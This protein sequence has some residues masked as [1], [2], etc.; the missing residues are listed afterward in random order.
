MAIKSM[1]FSITVLISMFF[2]DIEHIQFVAIITITAFILFYVKVPAT[3]LLLIITFIWSLWY[4][5]YVVNEVNRP[6]YKTA[7][8]QKQPPIKAVQ[9]HIITAQVITLVNNKKRLSF[10]VSV[11]NT[12]HTAMFFLQ[13]KLALKWSNP[14]HAYPGEVGI[15]Q[16]WRFK[17]RI[18]D[19]DVNKVENRFSSIK[20][21]LLSRHVRHTGLIMKGEVIQPE[22]SLRG[23]LYQQF[24]AIL[25]SAPNPMIM[26]LTF[27]DRSYIPN[28]LWTQFK[29]LGIGH[30]VA[31]SG[32]HIGLIFGFS[33]VCSL[34]ILRWCKINSYLAISLVF[35]LVM[36]VFYAWLAG[37]SLPALRAIV[38]LCIH[39]L[40][41]IQYYKITLFQLF[42]SMLFVTL[43]FDPLTVFSVSFWLSFSAMAA[44]FI[45]IWYINNNQNSTTE[46]SLIRQVLMNS[47]HRL[48]IVVYSQVL[49]TFLILPLQMTVFSGF[50][51]L[52]I[53]INLI[54]IP[55]FSVLILPVLLFAVLLVPLMPMLSQFLIWIANHLLN[56]IQLLWVSLTANN[57]VWFDLTGHINT[58]FYN[59]FLMIFVLLIIAVFIKPLRVACNSISLLLL[60]LLCYTYMN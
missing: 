29:L 51:W 1:L 46:N 60:P 35:S 22:F 37:F 58:M 13:P 3:W 16:I 44:V 5:H 26:A 57:A 50:S 21:R 49:L 2:V 25:P 14:D 41:R 4:K 52:S 27:G 42:S 45:L 19:D 39:C 40:Y 7:F 59:C 10:D 54:F 6:F 23:G 15:G 8:Q 31:I 48:K 34:R 38:L 12:S 53:I 56:Y 47:F 24:K 36:A 11:I 43:L 9:D 32:L 30:L 28:D 18:M 33:Y 20:S 17:I 55:V